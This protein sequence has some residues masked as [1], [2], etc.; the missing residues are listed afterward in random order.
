MDKRPEAPWLR[1]HFLDMLKVEE[2]WHEEVTLTSIANDPKHHRQFRHLD[3]EIGVNNERNL[4][5]PDL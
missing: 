5:L 2:I 4:I 1:G 3:R